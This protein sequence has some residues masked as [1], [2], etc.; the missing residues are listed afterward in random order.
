MGW[1]MMSKRDL[2]RIE[3]LTQ[4]DDGYIGVTTAANLMN[5]S[6][7]HVYRLL[8]RFR[9]EGPGG[10]RH[11]ARGRRPNND[12][13]PDRG[14]IAS[15]CPFDACYCSAAEAEAVASFQSSIKVPSV[16]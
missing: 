5:M 2:N 4:V 14:L 10:I 12:I 9:S 3:V 8:D 16:L 11:R 13:H 15:L 7:R 1:V 6:R